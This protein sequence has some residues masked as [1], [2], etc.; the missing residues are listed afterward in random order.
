MFFYNSTTLFHFP[1]TATPMVGFSRKT[2]LIL[3]AI[4][5]G[6]SWAWSG[7]KFA[8]RLA[9]KPFQL[10]AGTKLARGALGAT[11]AGA[12]T[13]LN[14]VE[15]AEYTTEEIVKGVGN[16]TIVPLGIWGLSSLQSIWIKLRYLSMDALKA[17][18]K[19]P[20]AI[21]KSPLELIRGVRDSIVSIPKNLYALGGNL[22]K[23]H[24]KEAVGSTR[25]LVK[26]ALLP[27]ITRPLE[28][29]VKPLVRVG[30][31]AVRSE[32][33]KLLAV[34]QGAEHA[35]GGVK[36]ILNSYGT[37]RHKVALNNADR[38]YK[39]LQKQKEKEAEEKEAEKKITE[40]DKAKGSK[41]G[42]GGE[43]KFRKTG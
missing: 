28:G 8:A 38:E 34:K 1:R 4:G 41:K 22:V 18:V 11:V 14:V 31:T 27:P 10:A 9:A 32:L 37:A 12:K 40:I 33:I 25:K 16:A 2:N 15:T 3:E 6:F 23:L 26:E 24:I 42:K 21:A 39:A 17:A 36:Q 20:I 30:S 19:T 43:Q 13:G 7:T 35:V 29:V 5:K